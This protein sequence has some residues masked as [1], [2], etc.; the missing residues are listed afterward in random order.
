V[1]TSLASS[2]P[3]CNREAT[4]EAWVRVYRLLAEHPQ[5]P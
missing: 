4:H 5:S 2:S 1:F 3:E